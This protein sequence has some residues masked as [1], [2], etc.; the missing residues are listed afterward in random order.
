VSRAA[1]AAALLPPLPQRSAEPPIKTTG[2]RAGEREAP[3]TARFDLTRLRLLP[4]P[5]RGAMVEAEE[6][7]VQPR[8]TVGPA[9][10][11][12][13]R[14]ADGVAETVMRMP[15][16]AMETE[17]DDAGLRRKCAACKADERVQRESVAAVEARTGA[18]TLAASP[19]ELNSG[20]TP[21]SQPLLT[22]YEERLGRDLSLVR[23]HQ[24]APARA[25]N[26]SISARAF[27]YGSHIW[28]GEGRASEPSHTLAHELAHVLQQTQ[29]RALRREAESA[30]PPAGPR[31]QRAAEGYWIPSDPNLATPTAAHNHSVEKLGQA[32]TT[33]ITEAP[34]PNAGYGGGRPGFAD[35]YKA[36][37]TV[38]VQVRAGTGRPGIPPRLSNFDE[39]A[40]WAAYGHVP[41]RGGAHFN[42]TTEGRP[43]LREDDDTL[44]G[45]AQAPRRVEIG[46]VKAGFQAWPRLSASRQLDRYGTGIARVAEAVNRLGGL[47]IWDPELL[48]LQARDVI[49]PRGYSPNA[50]PTSDSMVRN[51][52]LKKSARGRP[53]RP[54]PPVEGHLI[55]GADPTH[56]G[57]WNYFWVPSDLPAARALAGA[58]GTDWADLA[59]RYEALVRDMRQSPK[60]IRRR[61]RAM[62]PGGRPARRGRFM[63][64]RTRGSPLAPRRP[65]RQARREY[66]RDPFDHR[67]WERRRV[68]L[69]RDFGVYQRRH[70]TEFQN[71]EITATAQEAELLMQRRLAGYTARRPQ[72]TTALRLRQFARLDFLTSARGWAVGWLRKIFGGAYVQIARAYQRISERFRRRMRTP[73]GVGG[74]WARAAFLALLNVL[75]A[76]AGIVLG[77]TVAILAQRIET[78]MET[79]VS[80]LFDIAREDLDLSGFEELIADLEAQRTRI[81]QIANTGAAALAERFLGPF[82]K[83]FDALQTTLQGFSALSTVASLVQ[84]GVRIA[85]CGA[86]PVAGCL[87]NL[88][89]GALELVI[90]AV[91]QSCWFL[92]KV[93]PYAMRLGFLASLPG[94]LADGIMAAL[95]AILPE[96]LHHLL[97]L[98]ALEGEV[99][100]VAPPTQSE[101]PCEDGP[102]ARAPQ[103]PQAVLDRI[104][105]LAEIDPAIY[106]ELR[107]WSRRNGVPGNTPVD[108][109]RFIA[110]LDEIRSTGMSAEAL[111][112]RLEA[113]QRT[114]E[115][116]DPVA[117]F[118]TEVRRRGAETTAA[119]RAAEERRQRRE[120]EQAAAASERRARE[121]GGQTAGA[122]ERAGP[123]IVD[124]EIVDPLPAGATVTGR[125]PVNP[126]FPGGGGMGFARLADPDAAREPGDP[127]RLTFYYWINRRWVV[128]RNVQAEYRGRSSLNQYRMLGYSLYRPVHFRA[129][130]DSRIFV[131]ETG[132][133][134]VFLDYEGIIIHVG[135]VG[136]S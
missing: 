30:S 3:D 13:E 133:H 54:N 124:A 6:T 12:F 82:G 110:L 51:L 121:A 99:R 15:G 89:I 77:R 63:A 93:T 119:N 20:G 81:E 114:P 94:Q 56:P 8:L 123:E 24:G 67:L 128:L 50:A 122:G 31:V 10:D 112:A 100:Q 66:N 9:E 91:V 25:M 80:E 36:R 88:A 95:R 35:L 127:I 78:C 23:L 40:W 73:R 26:D 38:G 102:N 7:P 58:A 41:T 90:S 65:Q 21:L 48:K 18:P 101:I 1:P 70:P 44:D 76:G 118:V 43:F 113:A 34:I 22:F 39:Q 42:H 107:R 59:A 92:R 62:A 115:A 64:R 61:P 69:R 28:L 47:P 85:A 60:N 14:E 71:L 103:A 33:F 97:C 45:I 37:T 98:D 84:W 17:E 136:G 49:L 96:S 130:G 79:K 86:P 4:R 72:A 135:L 109:D 27:T 2:A 46:E 125:A 129:P 29:P 120:A 16:S 11:E 55:I 32:N 134:W 53:L 104:D 75:K 19:A 52:V 57:V 5:Q 105:E 132:E 83:L 111:R 131:E 68:T 74:T 106:A 116:T 126:Q 117:R 87:W 108:Y